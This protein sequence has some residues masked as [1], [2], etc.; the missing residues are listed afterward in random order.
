[1]CV[2]V[3]VCVSFRTTSGRVCVIVDTIYA[4]V[5]GSCHTSTYVHVFMRVRLCVC[6]CGRRGVEFVLCV[7]AVSLSLCLAR[8][9]SGTR[10]KMCLCEFIIT[11][12]FYFWTQGASGQYARWQDNDLGQHIRWDIRAQQLRISPTL[13]GNHN[14]FWKSQRQSK[15]VQEQATPGHAPRAQGS[16]HVLETHSLCCT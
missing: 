1:M 12:A 15:Q 10:V 9:T 2:W 16:P 8:M 7:F 5:R 3:C 14:R 4:W 6:V 13:R 11:F